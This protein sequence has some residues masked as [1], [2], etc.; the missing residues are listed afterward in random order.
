MLHY[1][2]P[3]HEAAVLNDSPYYTPSSVQRK[4]QLDLGFLPSWYAR[5]GEKVWLENQLD[6]E[7][8][9]FLSTYSLPAASVV[10]PENIALHSPVLSDEKLTFWGVSPQSIQYFRNINK[11]YHLSLSLPDW[12]PRL[13]ELCSRLQ[14]RMCLEY[15]IEHIPGISSELLPDYYTSPEDIVEKI[16]KAKETH[17]VKSPYSSSGR[18]LLWLSPGDTDR[19]S[20]QL[21][22]GMFNRQSMV[23]LEKAL[24]KQLDFSMQFYSDGKGCVTFLGLSAFQTDHRGNYQGTEVA[25]Q[26][27]I[28]KII[29]A[30]FPDWPVYYPL[31]KESMIQ[32]LT[33]HYASVYQGNMGVDMLIYRVGEK[34]FL[35]P[36]V[37]INVRTTMG[38]LALRLHEKVGDNKVRGHF[39]LDFSNQVGELLQKDREMKERYPLEVSEGKIVSGYLPLCPVRED[40]QYRA[41]L[42]L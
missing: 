14:A 29:S 40:S 8:L 33:T 36:C 42:L 19:A 27:C 3:G 37:E 23:S 34:T 20:R 25:S 5:E 12:N 21:L 39:Q 17:I 1:F 22:Q 28:D 41:C 38:Y 13:K 15:L 32:F 16:K 26:S 11:K 35:Y 31:C 6:E 7:Y 9:A 24:D 2:N 30:S 18:G 4:M 10:C